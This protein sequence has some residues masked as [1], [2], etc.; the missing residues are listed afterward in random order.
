M[1][2]EIVPYLLLFPHKHFYQTFLFSILL[3][4]ENINHVVYK[5]HLFDSYEFQILNFL[6]FN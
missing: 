2:V 6:S 1:Y 5:W 4:L 3:I